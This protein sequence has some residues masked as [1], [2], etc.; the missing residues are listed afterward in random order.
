MKGRLKNELIS[1]DIYKFSQDPMSKYHLII[2]KKFCN[3]LYEGKINI[4]KHLNVQYLEINYVFK[5]GIFHKFEHKYY[6]T[7]AKIISKS[8]LFHTLKYEL[9]QN[10]I[11]TK[12]D[13]KPN[14]DRYYGQT[15]H[16]LEWINNVRNNENSKNDSFHSVKKLIWNQAQ[17]RTEN[18]WRSSEINP[19]RQNKFDLFCKYL[20]NL[21]SFICEKPRRYSNRTQVNYDNKDCIWMIFKQTYYHQ[22]LQHLEIDLTNC[23]YSGKHVNISNHPLYHIYK[24]KRLE[25]L[26]LILPLFGESYKYYVPM[27]VNSGYIK[28]EILWHL[29]DLS[30]QF[31]SS[32]TTSFRN[33]H[34]NGSDGFIPMDRNEVIDEICKSLLS[35]CPNIKNY[36]FL[37][38]NNGDDTEFNHL[39]TC[40]DKLESLETDTE[41]IFC[42]NVR[43]ITLKKLTIRLNAKDEFLEKYEYVDFKG[44]R[45][46]ERLYCIYNIQDPY[47][48]EYCLNKYPF[49]ITRIKEFINFIENQN[50]NQHLK[51][52]GIYHELSDDINTIIKRKRTKY[53]MSDVLSYNWVPN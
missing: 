45:N 42:D 37:A 3:A 4:N 10:K 22:K 8:P 9:N 52:I 5:N 19:F 48:R 35:Q 23:E 18:G 1:K 33:T 39:L 53:K 27:T 51:H 36:V 32:F 34:T 25:S 6:S 47:Y 49:L 21:I 14:M 24:F 44:F 41:N 43:M 13:S 16:L 46:L 7:I 26:K 15:G 50:D 40:Y 38:N 20:P 11:Q 29:T 30:I 2:D 17:F 31:K 12:L 28:E